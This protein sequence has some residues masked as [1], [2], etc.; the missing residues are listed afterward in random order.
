MSHKI[1]ISGQSLN[2]LRQLLNLPGWCKTPGEVWCA[3]NLLVNVLPEFDLSWVKKPE[4]VAALSAANAVEYKAKDNQHATAQHAFE[5]DEKSR[6]LVRTC[7]EKHAESV[8]P[9]RYI[10]EL[11]TA[12]GFS[13]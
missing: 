3:G 4:E 7:L 13:I 8:R 9:D 6:D 2:L 11:Y 12:F 1:T 5:L 10:F